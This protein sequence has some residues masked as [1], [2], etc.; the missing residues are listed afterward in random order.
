MRYLLAYDIASPQRLRR[1]ARIMERHAIRIQKSV[2]VADTTKDGVVRLLDEVAQVMAP[3]YDIVQAWRLAQDQPSDGLL[4]GA[5]TPL[6]PDAVI[7]DQ[8]RSYFVE[9]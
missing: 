3:Q 4:R 9:E 5:V 7:F 1:V 6:A 8:G 2:F